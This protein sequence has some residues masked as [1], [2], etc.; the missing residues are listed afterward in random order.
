[1]LGN[2]RDNRHKMRFTRSL[3]ADDEKALIVGR[4]AELQLRKHELAEHIGH[5]VGNNGCLCRSLLI[6][7]AVTLGR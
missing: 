5:S 3:V 2:R 7:R 4:L 6:R 1:M